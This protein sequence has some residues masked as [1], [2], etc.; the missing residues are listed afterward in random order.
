MRLK[1]SFVNSTGRPQFITLELSTARFRLEPGDEAI[2][3]YESGEIQDEHASA[4]RVE[5]V[6][7][8]LVV[9]TSEEMLTYPDGT[10]LRRN[11]DLP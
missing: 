4:L 9:W 11:Y 6:D 10:P 5:L 7:G 3:S 8:E 1:Q 2:L